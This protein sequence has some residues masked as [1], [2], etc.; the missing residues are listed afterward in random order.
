M[1]EFIRAAPETASVVMDLLARNLDWPGSEEMA[2]RFRRIAVGRGL[3][4]PEE[5]AGPDPLTPVLGAEAEKA[6]AE[7]LRLRVEALK[8][9]VETLK[10]RAQAEKLA[11]EAEGQ[12]LDNAGKALLLSSQAGQLE[13]AVAAAVEAV[14]ARLADGGILRDSKGEN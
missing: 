10:L 14:L 12:E 11:R 1:V 13:A 7:A 3:A 6:E 4:E 5:G 8:E 9:Q 2:K